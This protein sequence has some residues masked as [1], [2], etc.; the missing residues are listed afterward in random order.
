MN[1]NPSLEESSPLL[2]QLIP[3]MINDAFRLTIDQT[4]VAK[5]GQTNYDPQKLN[6]FEVDGTDNQENL[7]QQILSLVPPPPKGSDNAK[8]KKIF[9]P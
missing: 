6:V 2:Q 4:F 1:T 7:W 9:V 8:N 5:K 3:R